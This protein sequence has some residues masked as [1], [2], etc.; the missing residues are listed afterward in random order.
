MEQE[1]WWWLPTKVQSIILCL[2]LELHS[3]KNGTDND[4]DDDLDED[5]DIIIIDIDADSEL[6]H[7]HCC[8]E[9]RG[10]VESKASLAS[11]PRLVKRFMIRG[12]IDDY[13]SWTDAVIISFNQTQL[14]FIVES[15]WKVSLAS[16]PR[17]ARALLYIVVKLTRDNWCWNH[18]FQPNVIIIVFVNFIVIVNVMR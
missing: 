9:F 6:W 14:F 17:S 1:H 3:Y 2:S 16:R 7:W 11:R 12:E 5:Q 4:K 8:I 18:Q 13:G 10:C 15:N